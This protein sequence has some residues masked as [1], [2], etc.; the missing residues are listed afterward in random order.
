MSRFARPT[1]HS[2][3]VTEVVSNRVGFPFQSPE[4]K[5]ER[6]EPVVKLDSYLGRYGSSRLI[7]QS[8]LLDGPPTQYSAVLPLYG[9]VSSRLHFLSYH[10][11]IQYLKN[12]LVHNSTASIPCLPCPRLISIHRCPLL[13]RH[14]IKRPFLTLTLFAHSLVQSVIARSGV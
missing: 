1:T 10:I 6:G 2:A 8:H 3:M 11:S 5:V 12:R 9:N 4:E 14:G 13:L 7:W